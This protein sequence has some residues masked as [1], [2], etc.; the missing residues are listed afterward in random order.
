MNGIRLVGE[1]RNDLDT[2]DA[3]AEDPIQEKRSL[4]CP[5]TQDIDYVR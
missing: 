4:T 3:A 1:Q 2:L 5:A